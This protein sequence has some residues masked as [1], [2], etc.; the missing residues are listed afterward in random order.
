MRYVFIF[1]LNISIVSL[2]FAIELETQ[3]LEISTLISKIKTAKSS[4]RRLLI[5]ELKIKLRDVN[6]EH[7]IKAMQELRKSLHSN[8]NQTGQNFQYRHGEHGYKSQ[9]QKQGQHQNLKKQY[10]GKK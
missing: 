5:N 2:S 8:S 10:Q 4:D 3:H 7:R 1:I 9:G 6:Q